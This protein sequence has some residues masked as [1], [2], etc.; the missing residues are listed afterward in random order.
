MVFLKAFCETNRVLEKAQICY[1]YNMTIFAPAKVNLHLAVMD[2]RHDGFHNLESL[3]LLIN[4][5]DYL[6]FELKTDKNIKIV[7]NEKN[8][9]ANQNGWKNYTTNHTNQHEH[10]NSLFPTPHSPHPTPHSL[11][12]TPHSPHPTPHT[13]LPTQKNIIYKAVILFK[14]LTGFDKGINIIVEKK[15]P[16]GGG[17][18]GGSSDAAAALL[19]LNK[20]S[21]SPLNFKQLLEAAANLGSDVPFFIHKTTA[22]R[23]T[24][25][26]EIIEPV[27]IPRLFLT[28]V[29]P[30][31]PSGTAAAFNLLDKQRSLKNFNREPQ[32]HVPLIQNIFF[33]SA[34]TGKIFD[35]ANSFKNF[36]NDFL[37]VFPEKEKLIYKNIIFE[38]QENGAVYANLSGTGSTCFGVFND[39]EKAEKAAAN[40][41][42]KWEFVHR[43]NPVIQ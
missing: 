17:L 30:G 40:L 4:F 22:A 8:F 7:M 34:K 2:K 1:C 38:L 13:P 11:L 43:C 33:E 42:G 35:A 15:I 32:I 23:V 26:G 18:G 31:F 10:K 12:P 9:T 5:G 21:G 25:R 24:G 39:E 28:L 37:E 36:K 29:N 19:A 16:V 3:F 20:I 14:E 41:R 27:E 6:H